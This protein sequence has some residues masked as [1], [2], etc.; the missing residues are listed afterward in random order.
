MNSFDEIEPKMRLAG[1]AVG[2]TVEVVALQPAVPTSATIVYRST[3]GDLGQRVLTIDDLPA[4][5]A[6]RTPWS[7][8]TGA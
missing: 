7:P 4:N 1:V 2:A 6:V 5:W 3:N 8:S